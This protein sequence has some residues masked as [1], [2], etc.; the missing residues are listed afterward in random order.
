MFDTHG[1]MDEVEQLLLNARLRDELEPYSDDS[2]VALE[3]GRMT[4]AMENDFLQSMLA[5]ERAPA[6][7]IQDWFTPALQLP[8]PERLGDDDL[9]RWLWIAI[10]RLYQKHVVLDFTDHLNDR[11]LY[12]IIYRDILPS[13]EKKL[14]LP[15][16]YL[17]WYCVDDGDEETWLQYYAS[18][19]ERRMWQEENGRDPPPSRLPPFPR[20][21]PNRPD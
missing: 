1:P 6:V 9:H 2:V 12:T 5:W 17:H 20:Q 11:Q 4:L 13:C 8:A 21:M 18:R 15:R 7:P 3:H 19:T 10:E 16:R 14:E